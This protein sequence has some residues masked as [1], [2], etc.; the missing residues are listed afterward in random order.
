MQSDAQR[1]AMADVMGAAVAALRAR[2]FT[3]TALREGEFLDARGEENRRVTVVER[4]RGDDGDP[5]GPWTNKVI[6]ETG[7]RL[8]SGPCHDRADFAVAQ[9]SECGESLLVRGI[10]SAPMECPACGATTD[11]DS[12]ETVNE[13]SE[14]DA[15]DDEQSALNGFAAVN[16]GGQ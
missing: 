5:E 1:D 11:D 12:D 2:P 4:V 3:G 7:E 14:E 13:E 15:Q 8:V 9:C 16:G 10:E 6:E